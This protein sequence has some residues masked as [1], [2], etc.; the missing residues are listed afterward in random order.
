MESFCG[1]DKVVSRRR[2]AALLFKA[3]ANRKAEVRLRQFR[4][5]RCQP[6]SMFQCGNFMFLAVARGI[7]KISEQ[8]ITHL[9][10]FFAQKHSVRRI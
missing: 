2:P 6:V 3:T 4:L 9:D 8:K 5:R 1:S 7:L 10:N